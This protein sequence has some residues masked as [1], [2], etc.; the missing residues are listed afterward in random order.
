MADTETEVHL[1]MLCHNSQPILDCNESLPKGFLAFA[2]SRI[3]A[4][5]LVPFLFFSLVLLLA[6]FVQGELEV[7]EVVKTIDSLRVETESFLEKR[8]Q[9]S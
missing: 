9:M 6:N 3:L 8:I 2:F 1:A 4:G 7:E 5:F